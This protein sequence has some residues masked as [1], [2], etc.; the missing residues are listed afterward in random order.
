MEKKD[1]PQDG[2]S[3]YGDLKYRYYVPD[4]NGDIECVN[5][6]GWDVMY[7][8]SDNY[9]ESHNEDLAGILEGVKKG[10]LS[11]LAYYMNKFTMDAKT[12]GRYVGLSKW[13]VKRHLKPRGFNCLDDE[14]LKRYASVFN[15]TVEQLK[16]I[17]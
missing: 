10:E 13:R 5:S 9:W 12:L 4:E 16:E 8:A 6:S 7:T 2:G 14:A 15:I 1:V 3:K 17:P 11:P